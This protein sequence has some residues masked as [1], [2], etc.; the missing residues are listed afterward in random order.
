MSQVAAL[1]L[2]LINGVTFAVFAYDKRASERRHR[3]VPEARLLGLAIAGG[4]AAAVLAQQALR[5]KTRKEPFWTRLW[6]I[7]G[8][9]ILA[10]LAFYRFR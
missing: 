3:R 5:H 4:A 2:L 6:V 10:L 1:Y 8:L 7:A 9:Q